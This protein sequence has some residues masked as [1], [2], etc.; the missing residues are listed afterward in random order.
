MAAILKKPET[1]IDIMQE[2]KLEQ[3][4]HKGKKIFPGFLPLF[5]IDIS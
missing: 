1:H 3:V 4:E 5:P 2:W